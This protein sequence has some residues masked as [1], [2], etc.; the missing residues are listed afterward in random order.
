M[1][2]K[3]GRIRRLTLCNRHLKPLYSGAIPQA[4][5]QGEGEGYD[6]RLAEIGLARETAGADA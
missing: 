4:T 6:Q 1:G 3:W 2:G 5:P